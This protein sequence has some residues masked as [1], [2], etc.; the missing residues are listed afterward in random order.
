MAPAAPSQEAQ[1]SPAV[2]TPVASS[3]QVLPAQPAT[4]PV[5]SINW[6]HI[7]ALL[8]NEPPPLAQAGGPPGLTSSIEDVTAQ[9]QQ[10]VLQQ[11][12]ALAHQAERTIEAVTRQA[13]AAHNEQ[14]AE[15]DKLTLERDHNASIAQA[16]A[17]QAQS[18]AAIAQQM[19]ESLEISEAAHAS[20]A[21]LAQRHEQQLQTNILVHKEKESRFKASYEELNLKYNELQQSYQSGLAQLQGR[22]D[23]V[24]QNAQA[25]HR[26]NEEGKEELAAA[27]ASSQQETHAAA[28]S[29][30]CYEYE[31]QARG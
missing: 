25:L 1:Q 15:V 10:A 20:E 26:A 4:T 29:S 18:A 13:Q 27:L 28:Q 7:Q 24:D 14:R 8:R 2:P 9:A 23:A 16:H 21:A 3:S 17:S 12:A 19:A 6:A 5:P 30:Q 11:R 22:I 31:L